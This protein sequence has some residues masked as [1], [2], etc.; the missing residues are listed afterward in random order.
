MNIKQL[1]KGDNVLALI[2]LLICIINISINIRVLN[3]PSIILSLIGITGI[4]FYY[5]KYEGFSYFIFIW[6]LG[7]IVI[8]PSSEYDISTNRIVYD[9]IWDLSQV[10]KFTIGSTWNIESRSVGLQFNILP[11]IYLIALKQMRS[12]A[13]IGK[14]LNFKSFRSSDDYAE[15]FPLS[16]KVLR[17][18]TIDVDENWLQVE[19]DTPFQYGDDTIKF[20]LI[21]VKGNG[22]LKTKGKN[23]IVF[24]RIILNEN[25]L[26]E[27]NNDGD[28]FPFLQWAFCS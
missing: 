14:V 22:T 17:K 19:L 28:K 11:I 26:Q 25:D 23:Q 24:F 15:I 9:P 3:Y 7:Q 5:K 20:V 4:I 1:L 18:A 16:G 6:I 8:I 21:K 10:L 27:G 13:L 2:I 12:S